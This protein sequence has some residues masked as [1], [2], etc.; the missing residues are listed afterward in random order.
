MIHLIPWFAAGMAALW[1]ARRAFFL[2]PLALRIER[3][4]LFVPPTKHFDGEL[5]VAHLTDLH[6]RGELGELERRVVAA[7][8]SVRP[9]IIAVTGDYLNLREALPHLEALLNQLGEVAPVYA[10]LG[11][12]D[13]DEDEQTADLIACLQRSRVRLLRNEAVHV[14]V[15]G[16]SLVVAG[17]DDPNTGRAELTRALEAGEALLPHLVRSPAARLT[18]LPVLLLAHSPEIAIQADPRV[19]LYLTGHTHG[20]QI[21]LPGGRALT[22]NTPQ[23]RGYASGAYP[24]KPGVLYV[25]RGVGTARIRARLFCPPELAVFTLKAGR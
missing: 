1:G 18:D 2:E 3:H 25:N 22:T 4:T 20:G 8:R 6:L 12:N 19:D 11:D 13:F 5:R 23:I 9:H 16:G 14:A 17:V 10:V 24:L 7:T 21:C 15:A